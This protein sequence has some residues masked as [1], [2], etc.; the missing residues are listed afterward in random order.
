MLKINK[1][2]I[3]FIAILFCLVS[4]VIIVNVSA[5]KKIELTS[6]GE[7]YGST[8]GD[9]RW[10]PH[11]DINHDGVIDIH[12]LALASK[13]GVKTSKRRT[14]DTYL[15]ESSSPVISVNPEN[16]YVNLV[17]DNFSIDIDVTG[18]EL[19]WAFEFKLSWDPSLLNVTK[20]TNGSFLSQGGDLYCPN[21]TNYDEGWLMF[22]CTLL[23]PATSQSGSGTL[24][25]LDFTTLNEGDTTLHLYDTYLLDDNLDDYTHGTSD[26]NAFVD[27][28][29]PV[30]TI[31]S[32]QNGKTYWNNLVTLK[33]G[34]N[35]PASWCGYSLD[36]GDNQTLDD[37]VNTTLNLANG[38][39][40]ITV[41]AKDIVGNE[42]SDSVDFTVEACKPNGESCTHGYECCSHGCWFGTCSSG[43][44]GGGGGGG[45]CALIDIVV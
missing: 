39:H 5:G 43:Y 14:R 42:G 21:N 7:I 32:P 10:D 12:D 15:M 38:P 1:K 37:C 9:P 8:R 33:Y 44:G 30:V 11:A 24:A 20:V 16:T 17:G 3:V 31:V 18:A 28:T 19:T 23:E 26:G 29:P 22:A 6:V 2:M 34:V 4:F 27:Q 41:Y 25:T 36:G 45:A 35:E 13:S 40:N